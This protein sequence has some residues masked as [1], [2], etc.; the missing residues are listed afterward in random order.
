MRQVA[1]AATQTASPGQDAEA[2]PEPL[3]PGPGGQPSAGLAPRL[4]SLEDRWEGHAALYGV[5]AA[6]ATARTPANGAFS[7]S[8]LPESSVCAASCRVTCVLCCVTPSASVCCVST[9][10]SRT[11]ARRPC[12]AV[13]S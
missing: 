1:D 11:G 12:C 4:L 10:A 2:P 7:T 5:N 8:V 3:Q 6:V 9:D 13:C